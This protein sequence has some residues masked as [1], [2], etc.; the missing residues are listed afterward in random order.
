MQK[1][2][3]GM[4]PPNQFAGEDLE[5]ED[6]RIWFECEEC[7]ICWSYIPGSG[8]ATEDYLNCPNGCDLPQKTIH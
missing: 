7:G 3:K 2:K 4:Q 6:I 8:G 5:Q 1:V